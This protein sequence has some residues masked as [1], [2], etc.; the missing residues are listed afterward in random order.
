[1]ILLYVP[2]IV[3]SNSMPTSTAGIYVAQ[4]TDSNLL[5]QHVALPVMVVTMILL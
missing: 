1:M 4:A 5:T 3:T 2:S